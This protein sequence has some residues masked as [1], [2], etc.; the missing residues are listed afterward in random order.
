MTKPSSAGKRKP[1]R[2]ASSEVEPAKTPLDCE[3]WLDAAENVIAEGGFSKARVLPLAKK[4]GVTRGSFY[5]HFESHPA[6]ILKIIERWKQRQLEELAT[7]DGDTSEPIRTLENILDF[8][9]ARLWLDARRNKVE[10]ALRDF[11]GGNK[12]AAKT[13]AEVDAARTKIFYR[14]MFALIG[15]KEEAE[16]CA[17]LFYAQL[18]GGQLMSIYAAP[19]QIPGIIAKLKQAI[20]ASLARLEVAVSERA[21]GRLA[22]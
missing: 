10:T 9:A 3:A 4:L 20:S 16:S 19:S 7:W 15:S 2:A 6:F 5:W 22:P 8:V 1:S 11:A 18:T 21:A 14:L 12:I 17:L 13:M